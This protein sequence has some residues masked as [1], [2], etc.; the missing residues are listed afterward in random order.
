M[1]KIAI[2]LLVAASLGAVFSVGTE[3]RTGD[4]KKVYD[5]T[6]KGRPKTAIEEL[7][8]IIQAAL[9]DKK[10][11]EATKAITMK[12]ALEGQIQ[13]NKP[14]ERIVR[15]EAVMADLPA[16]MKPTLEVVLANW[17]WH[18]FKQN[19]WRFMQRTQTAEPPGD[20]ITSWDLPRILAEIDEHFT[21]ALEAEEQLKNTPVESFGD[22]LQKGTMPDAYR[23][24]MFDFV[25]HEALQFYGAGEQAGSQA[26]D[27]FV[28]T[29]DSAIFAPLPEFLSWQIESTDTRSP[30]LKAIRL[31][32]KLLSF[33]QNDDDPTALADADLGRLTF[34]YNHAFG[35]EKDARYKAALEKFVDRW[36]DRPIAATALHAWAS[37]LHGENL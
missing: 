15:F 9:R 17:Y 14:E 10:Y 35:E 2:S 12:I 19:Q 6:E 4:W 18:Y 3:Q 27:A 37:V 24:T 20:D 16:E 29:A 5:A 7:E 8:P 31:Y 21:A 13:G 32:Q 11:G 1:G 25:A 26:E 22:L 34:G 23:P 33:H 36:N 30:I 28:L